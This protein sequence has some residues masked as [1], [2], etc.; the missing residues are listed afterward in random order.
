M[1]EGVGERRR[2]KLETSKQHG[3]KK[4]TKKKKR[5]ITSLGSCLNIKMQREKKSTRYKKGVGR[6]T[7]IARVTALWSNI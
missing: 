2:R 4:N 1:G 3:R 7:P 6:S 5:K